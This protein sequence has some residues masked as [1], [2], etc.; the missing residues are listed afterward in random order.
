[1][2]PSPL[3]SVLGEHC[4]HCWLIQTYESQ[5]QVISRIEVVVIRSY[6]RGSYVVVC[7]NKL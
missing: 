7:E 6:H 1:M 4:E 5:H 3:L 2:P